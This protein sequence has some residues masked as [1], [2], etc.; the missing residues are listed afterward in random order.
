MMKNKC[1]Y[2]RRNYTPSRSDQLFCSTKC[3]Y[4]YSYIPVPK[5]N[6]CDMLNCDLR[7]TYRKYAPRDCP[8]RVKQ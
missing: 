1:L 5:C 4:R 2:C 6:D 7:N 8:E 3:R